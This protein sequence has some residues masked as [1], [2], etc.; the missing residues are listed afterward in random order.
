M[1]LWYTERQTENVGITCKAKE[2]L[3]TEQTDF[4]HLAVID[5][6]QYGRMLTLDGLV[7]TTDKDE[8]VYHEMISHLAL[9][10]HPNPE[11][12]LVI[13]GG[14]GGTIREVVK[15][16]KVKKAVL[17]EI[18]ERVIEVCKE[19]F[20]A[21]SS[22]LKGHPK[23]EVLVADGIKY[24]YEN[25]DSFDVVLIDSTDPIGPAQGLFS[26]E[27]YQKTF[28]CLRQDGI[29]VAQTESPF[30]NG[31]LISRLYK[32]ISSIYPITKLYTASV[33]TYPSG[34]WSFTMGSK[35]YDPE[36]VQSEDIEKID[37]KYYNGDVHQGAFKLPAFVRELLK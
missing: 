36:T 37:T 8:F 13:G 15:H 19:Y 26:K 2:T 24:V 5:T 23:V 21:I 29:M 10:T 28:G 16:N 34:F 1:E 35:K 17:V 14:D 27:F 6:L 22:A 32:D 33:P 20:P 3:H 18:D 11:R 30:Y 12:V 4:Q 9:N 25:K 7:M 31:E